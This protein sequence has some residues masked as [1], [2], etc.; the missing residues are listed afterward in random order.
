MDRYGDFKPTQ[1]D[2]HIEL[3][4]REDWLVVPVSRTRDSGCRAES[5]FHTALEIFGGESEDCEVH[6]FGHWGPGWF[7]IIIINPANADL[8]SKAE[9]IERALENYPVLDDEDLSERE[10][11][12]MLEA[13]DDYGAREFRDAL[14]RVLEPC[15]D[16][17]SDTEP[18][19]PQ[20]RWCK[21]WGLDVDICGCGDCIET[22]SE[23]IQ[24]LID[25]VDE[26]DDDVL[27]ELAA[28]HF[29]L[30]SEYDGS[31]VYFEWSKKIDA[32]YLCDMLQNLI[33]RRTK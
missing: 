10:H 1:F 24:A 26:M 21:H 5:N 20:Q 4:E 19:D 14:T 31:G 22:Q 28:D 25:F 23:W 32:E 3:D 12:A 2:R 29:D 15:F 27:R 18:A 6:R 8:L 33:Q 13:W 16:E 9:D 7:E 11:E 30:Q 17:Y